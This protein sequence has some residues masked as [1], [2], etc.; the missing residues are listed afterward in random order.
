MNGKEL[1]T[2]GHDKPKLGFVLS[3]TYKSDI[4]MHRQV[5]PSGGKMGGVSGLLPSNTMTSSSY[6]GSTTCADY[7]EWQLHEVHIFV[8]W[9]SSSHNN[10]SDDEQCWMFVLGNVQLRHI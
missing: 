3:S 10:Y 1:L 9:T 5:S 2:Q 4:G 6:P 8:Y 7:T